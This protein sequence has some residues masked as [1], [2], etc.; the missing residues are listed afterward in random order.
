MYHQRLG[1]SKKI[2]FHKYVNFFSRDFIFWR[3]YSISGNTHH[4]RKCADVLTP[5]KVFQN[6]AT[7]CSKNQTAPTGDLLSF[8][9]HALQC[10]SVPEKRKMRYSCLPKQLSTARTTSRHTK[11]R[12]SK[13]T[14]MR[15]Q[16]LRRPPMI[17]FISL[18]G[19]LPS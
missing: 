6:I 10:P 19:P 12:T 3:S 17:P 5:A 11:W 16:T 18:A 1:H 15:K 14:L 7:Y 13:T 2:F 4:I 9:L 8:T